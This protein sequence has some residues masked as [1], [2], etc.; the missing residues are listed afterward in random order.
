MLAGTV[1]NRVSSIND[2]R[3]IMDEKMNFSEHVDVIGYCDA[4]IYQNTLIRVQRSI[5]SEV[6]LH[7][8]GSSEAGIG[9]LYMEP[10]L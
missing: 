1:L 3:I 5:H 6:S 9:Q 10:I 7:V 2:L 4:G 8:I